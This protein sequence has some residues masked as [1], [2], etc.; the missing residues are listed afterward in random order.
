MLSCGYLAD[1]EDSVIVVAQS[2]VFTL[3]LS[4]DDVTTRHF[5]SG[6]ALCKGKIL[7]HNINHFFNFTTNTHCSVFILITV[8]Y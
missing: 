6:F 4:L 1:I 2:Q 7:K 5:T 3:E 8:F